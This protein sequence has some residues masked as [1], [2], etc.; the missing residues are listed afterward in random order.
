MRYRM[1]TPLNAVE[2]EF[3][4]AKAELASASRARTRAILKNPLGLDLAPY[5]LAIQV[6]QARVAAARQAL[7]VQEAESP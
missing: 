6:A 1:G 3:E 2:S 7:L 5:N 4:N